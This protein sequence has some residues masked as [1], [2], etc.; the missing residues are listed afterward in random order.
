M[1]LH[2]RDLRGT[3]VTLRSESGSTPY[4]IAPMTGHSPETLHR[5]LERYLARTDGRAGQTISK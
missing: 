1:R 5:I 2:F 4:Q 3:I